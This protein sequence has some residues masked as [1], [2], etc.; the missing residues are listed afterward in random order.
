R[1]K[2]PPHQAGGEGDQKIVLAPEGTEFT[3][4]KKAEKSYGSLHNGAYVGGRPASPEIPP[5]PLF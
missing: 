2:L 5:T 4:Q 3:E 1:G